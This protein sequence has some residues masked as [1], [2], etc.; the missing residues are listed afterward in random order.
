MVRRANRN[1]ERDYTPKGGQKARGKAVSNLWITIGAPT[2]P[3]NQWG[4]S[5]VFRPARPSV[6]AR[7]LS[8]Q[9]ESHG[10]QEGN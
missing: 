1:P 7:N 10:S 5:R 2:R 8:M 4:C 9:P 6:G 3:C